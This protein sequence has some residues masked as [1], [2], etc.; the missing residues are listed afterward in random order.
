M[1]AYCVLYP[2]KWKRNIFR[3]L[4]KGNLYFN[5]VTPLKFLYPVAIFGPPAQVLGMSHP[6]LQ[7]DIK[8][9]C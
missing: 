8:V 7:T 3:L 9:S 5:D 6:L 4:P 1:K 2:A